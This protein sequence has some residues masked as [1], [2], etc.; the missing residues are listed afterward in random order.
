MPSSP[1]DQ[2]NHRRKR[3]AQND[4]CAA[5]HFS[6]ERNGVEKHEEASVEFWPTGVGAKARPIDNVAPVDPPCRTEYCAANAPSLATHKSSKPR[7]LHWS[8]ALGTPDDLTAGP[9]PM[10]LAKAS[11]FPHKAGR[12]RRSVDSVGGAT[13]GS[14]AQETMSRTRLI[15]VGIGRNVGLQPCRASRRKLL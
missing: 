5:D 3:I 12:I 11:G 15:I 8:L 1:A 13:T 10:G 6:H 2:E 7:M 9:Q 14:K 4:G